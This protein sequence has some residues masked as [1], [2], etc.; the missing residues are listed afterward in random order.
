M[1]NDLFFNNEITESLLLE[2][3]VDQFADTYSKHVGGVAIVSWI[4]NG[5]SSSEALAEIMDVLNGFDSDDDSADE[6]DQGLHADT[7][8]AVCDAMESFGIGADTCEAAVNG[9]DAACRSAFLAIQSA[10][11]ESAQSIEDLLYHYTFTRNVSEAKKMSKSDFRLEKKKRLRRSRGRN[12]SGTGR[13]AR[14]TGARKVALLKNL[15]KA[16]RGFAKKLAQ[17]TKA[18]R[19]NAGFY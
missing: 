5:D 8:A 6:D 19:K 7:A 15:R 18:K 1:F 12:S 3:Q 10:M 17:R 11:D 13:K 16:R 9:D 14:I 4:Q 2:A